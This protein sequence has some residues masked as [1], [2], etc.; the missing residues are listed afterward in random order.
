MIKDKGFKIV[1]AIYILAFIAD[2]IS[3]LRMGELLKYLEA[4]PLYKYGGI[5]LIIL[6]NLA[7]AMAY[8]FLYKK[9]GVDVRFYTMFSLI[10]VIVIRFI[11]IKTNIAVAM[12]PPTLQQA[13]AVT[14]TMKTAVVKKLV[15]TNVIPFITCVSTWFFYRMDHIAAKKVL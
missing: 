15:L 8:Y 6:L 1:F 11:A 12:N 13:M 9:G 2:L 10:M 4:N 3:T 7:F 5:P 14:S